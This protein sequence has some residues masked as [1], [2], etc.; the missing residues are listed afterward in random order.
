[1][2]NSNAHHHSDVRMKYDAIM[3]FLQPA[4]YTLNS[5]RIDGRKYTPVQ[6]WREVSNW[7]KIIGPNFGSLKP[8]Q[9]AAQM[10]TLLPES[11]N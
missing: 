1:M 11:L 4:T 6:Y 2:N 8:T 9:H 7:L 3:H 5:E 10:F